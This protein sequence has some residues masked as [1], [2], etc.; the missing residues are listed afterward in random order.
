MPAD[1]KDAERGFAVDLEPWLA[2]GKAAERKAGHGRHGQRVFLRRTC[3][4][5]G[6]AIFPQVPRGKTR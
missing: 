3:G 4:K 2:D 6:G 1:G 5:I